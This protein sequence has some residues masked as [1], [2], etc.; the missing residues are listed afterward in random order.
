MIHAALGTVD[1]TEIEDAVGSAAYG[2]GTEYARQHAV[3]RMW[4]NSTESALHGTVHGRTGEFYS[5]VV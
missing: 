3:V 5:T 1:L 2:R 4:W